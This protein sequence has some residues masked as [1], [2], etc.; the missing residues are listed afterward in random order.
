MYNPPERR[1]SILTPGKQTLHNQLA[2]LAH[3]RLLSRIK[4]GGTMTTKIEVTRKRR[5]KHTRARNF[6]VSRKDRVSECS[7]GHQ[8]EPLQSMNIDLSTQNE[9]TALLALEFRMRTTV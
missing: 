6:L 1:Q 4:F 7:F 3:H 8:E 5:A 9:A 2:I